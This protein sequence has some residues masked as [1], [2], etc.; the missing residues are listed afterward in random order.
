MKLAMLVLLSSTCF[1]M[2]SI[3]PKKH[4]L[5]V[6]NGTGSGDYLKGEN[7]VIEAREAEPNEIFEQW[8]GFQKYIEDIHQT[9][10]VFIM[11]NWDSEVWATFKQGPTNTCEVNPEL[12]NPPPQ[13]FD[14]NKVKKYGGPEI[15]IAKDIGSWEVTAILHEVGFKGNNLTQKRDKFDPRPCVGS[16]KQVQGTFNACVKQDDGMYI[17]GSFDYEKCGGQTSGKTLGNMAYG[18]TMANSFNLH[19]GVEICFFNS[20]LARTNERNEKIRTSVRCTEWPY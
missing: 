1:G 8:D 13:D 9:K 14:W 18:G 11:P 2:G 4:H 6:T 15:S 10:T 20:G 19:K 7:V 16:P 3:G 17:C 12:C 5:T